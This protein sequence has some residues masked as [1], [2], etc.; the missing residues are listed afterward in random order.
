MLISLYAENVALI[1]KLNIDVSG[2][3]TVLTGETGGGKS[4]IVD[5]MALLCGAR[6]D[7]TLI[8]TGED[9]ACV[10]GVFDVSGADLGENA[11]L[12]GE[13]GKVSVYRRITSDGR[14][15]C[16]INGR[17]VPV[18]VLKQFV[19]GLLNIHGQQDTQSLSDPQTHIALLDIYAGDS[20]LLVS[21]GEKYAL[22][23]SALAECA[24]LEK[25]SEE[26]A[27]RMDVLDFQIKEL[28]NASVR[29]GEEAEL[30][31]E[32]SVLVNYEKI[33]ENVRT[34]LDELSGRGGALDKIYKAN[35]SLGRIEN[36]LAGSGDYI[37]RLQ[38]C[39]YEIDDIAESLKQGI[40]V[41][42]ESP[43]KRIDEIEER[44]SVISR[45]KRKYRTDDE[46]LALK[47]EELK[48]EKSELDLS[49]EYLADIR[50]ELEEKKKTLEKAASA[51]HEKRAGAAKRLEKEIEDCLATLDMPSVTFVV[52]FTDIPFC[53]N[54]ADGVEFLISANKGELPRPIA[55]IASGGELSRIMLSVKS[56]FA[57]TDGVRTV[58]F[59]EIDTGISGKTS[60]RLGIKLREL[61]ESGIQ[62]MCIT[63]SPQIACLADTHW[64]V[65]KGEEGERTYTSVKVLSFEERVEEI[66]RIMGGIT[67]TD[68]VRAAAR[69][70]LESAEKRR[71]NT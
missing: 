7:K 24:R 56:A 48:K 69:E 40:D 27:L 45:L 41:D 15:V 59:D 54:G 17:T 11:Y 47:L 25:M 20:E 26:K 10:E 21:Y 22:Y 31:N 60:E 23:T 30:E 55:R 16:R 71:K 52:E 2:G 53:E 6:G 4:I 44:L 51:L 38:S 43:E 8:R 68:S 61:A 29:A 58:V 12:A 50:A 28:E 19:S 42:C 36:V 46:G 57:K 39:T 65:S 34:A 9:F 37:K 64:L 14:G 66:A 62:I 32:R 63:H 18:T 49:D 67:V 3:F 5:S 1:K 35:D 13:D 33:Y 70:S